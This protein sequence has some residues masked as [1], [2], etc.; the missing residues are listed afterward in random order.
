MIGVVIVLV[1]TLGGLA[2][3]LAWNKWGMK[4]GLLIGLGTAL[5]ILALA[6]WLG[7]FARVGPDLRLR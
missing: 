6:R 3:T 4:G 2:A 7:V 5:I 1:L